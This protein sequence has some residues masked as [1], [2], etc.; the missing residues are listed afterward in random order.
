[1]AQ[2]IK[3]EERFACALKI[4]AASDQTDAALNLSKL[5]TSDRA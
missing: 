3:R 1:M 5:T 2:K 4:R